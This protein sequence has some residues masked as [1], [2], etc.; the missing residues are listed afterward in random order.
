META[1]VL[2]Y[3]VDY[4]DV[5]G[6]IVLEFRRWLPILGRLD[7]VV[8]YTPV[9]FWPSFESDD[10]SSSRFRQ[11]LEANVGRESDGNTARSQQEADL[12]RT[13]IS[14][15]QR[16]L[17]RNWHNT[18][19]EAAVKGADESNRVAVGED[20]SHSIARLDTAQLGHSAHTATAVLVQLVQ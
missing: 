10:F 7:E 20:E 8:G 2:T 3:C 9:E 5:G 14:S 17:D 18:R 1:K 12:L 4:F 16:H 6:R 11:S 15:R 13:S 19:M